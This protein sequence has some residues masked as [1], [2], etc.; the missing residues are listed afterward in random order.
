MLAVLLFYMGGNFC[1]PVCFSVHY[2]VS[3]RWSTLKVDFF[4]KGQK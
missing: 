1:Y 4:Q 3:E 2:A